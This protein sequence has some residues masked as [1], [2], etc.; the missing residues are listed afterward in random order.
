MEE[1]LT[2]AGLTPVDAYLR[3]YPYELS[4]PAPAVAIAAALA[5]RPRVIVADEPVEHAR[6]EHP[7]RHPE[8]ARRTRPRAGIDDRD[9]HPRPVDGRQPMRTGSRSCTS[10]GSSRPVR[11][12]RCSPTHTHPTRRP[13][14]GAC[15]SGSEPASGPSSSAA[16]LPILARPLRLPVPP[17]C[18]VA[19][20]RCRTIDPVL[21]VPHP[22]TPR[23]ASSWTDRRRER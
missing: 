11:P 9:D 12:A 3:R 18:P 17:R 10:A 6:R 20:E 23:H 2:A 1:A 7:R 21:V 16:R 13:A 5:L 14:L 4:R 19:I 15:R 8:F 22:A